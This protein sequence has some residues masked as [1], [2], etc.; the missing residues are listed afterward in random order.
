VNGTSPSTRRL[1][2]SN[3]PSATTRAASLSDLVRW[4]IASRSDCHAI[5]AHRSLADFER[6]YVDVGPDNY[7]WYQ[8]RFSDRIFAVFPIQGLEFLRKVKDA[9]P[10]NET[11]KLTLD[12]VLDRVRLELPILSLHPELRQRLHRADG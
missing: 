12:Q 11:E 7:V 2:R 9:F 10:R 3:H 1:L 8:D 5:P 4:Q 6:L